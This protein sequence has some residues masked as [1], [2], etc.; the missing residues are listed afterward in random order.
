MNVDQNTV[1]GVIIYSIVGVTIMIAYAIVSPTVGY[2]QF[3]KSKLGFVLTQLY[4]GVILVISAV[5]VD[6]MFPGYGTHSAIII[7][8]AYTIQ[9]IRKK[10][11]EKE[12]SRVMSNDVL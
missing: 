4:V 11:K 3:M 1:L 8:V 9:L 5:F 2:K 7:C 6:K 12:N 10:R